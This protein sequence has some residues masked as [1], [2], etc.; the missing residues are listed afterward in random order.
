MSGS[1]HGTSLGEDSLLGRDRWEHRAAWARR[2]RLRGKDTSCVP[3]VDSAGRKEAG[4]QFLPPLL[5]LISRT[6]TSCLRI[7]QSEREVRNPAFLQVTLCLLES[8]TK[9]L[10]ASLPAH[11]PP[12]PRPACRSVPPHL[13]RRPGL[14]V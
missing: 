12:P 8:L 6:N 4:M 14:L 9:I 11:C 13:K 1:E 7:F 3:P 5:C 2:P 10:A